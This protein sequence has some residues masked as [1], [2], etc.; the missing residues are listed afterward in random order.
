MNDINFEI[1][2]LHTSVIKHGIHVL[3][4]FVQFIPDDKNVFFASGVTCQNLYDSSFPVI[5][6][7]DSVVNFVLLWSEG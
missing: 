5:H 2:G 1:S 4:T 3:T 7:V 6:K